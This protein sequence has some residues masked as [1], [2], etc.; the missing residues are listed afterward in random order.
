MNEAYPLGEFDI[1]RGMAEFEVTK[2]LGK[3][4]MLAV[5]V[6]FSPSAESESVEELFADVALEIRSD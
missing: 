4:N 3:F 5:T 6:R 2:Q 1:A